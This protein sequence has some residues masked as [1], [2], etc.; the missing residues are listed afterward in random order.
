MKRNY[1]PFTAGMVTMMLL[2]GLVTAGLAGEPEAK[3][4]TGT[5]NGQVA[6]GEA[7]VALFNEEYVA[8]G[9]TRTTSKGAAVP[10]VLTY[11]DE[12]GDKR[13][14][15]DAETVCEVLDVAYGV[16]YNE[17][18]NCVDFGT[19]YLTDQNGNP[20]LDQEGKPELFTAQDDLGISKTIVNGE[21]IGRLGG[22][23]SVVV[24]GI[25]ITSMDA[26]SPE[27][28][29]HLESLPEDIRKEEEQRR[30]ERIDRLME[31]PVTA[32]YGTVRGMFTE[33]D[34]AEVDLST[35]SGSFL[36]HVS[37]QYDEKICETVAFSPLLGD[38]AQFEI[39]NQGDK[40]ILVK[41]W[42][43]FTV[44]TEH[45]EENFSTVRVPAG[46]TLKRTFRLAEDGAALENKL[47]ISAETVGGG[48]VKITLTAQQYR[49][50][51]ADAGK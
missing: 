21:T 27:Y 12:N 1:I 2:I 28:L 48:A 17:E 47:G 13:Y 29:E 42:R 51:T 45:S 33:V 10:T 41:V 46:E 6:Y 22:D 18:L 11:T 34:P 40:D 9:E 37:I 32:E 23:T 26:D 44:G 25:S 30:Q 31:T 36:D 43:P 20:R 24:D 50:G 3:T 7:G 8:A 15:V 35:Y 14:Y 38:Y 5:L 49:S 4:A 19:M 16:I 39:E